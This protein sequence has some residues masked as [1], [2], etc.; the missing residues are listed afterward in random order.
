MFDDPQSNATFVL[1]VFHSLILVAS[2]SLFLSIEKREIGRGNWVSESLH[3]TLRPPSIG[4][5]G[6]VASP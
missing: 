3:E 2:S 1:F 5:G 4:C 6:S